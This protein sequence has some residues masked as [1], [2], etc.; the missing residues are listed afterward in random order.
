VRVSPFR[1]ISGRIV[2][3]FFV[4]LVTFAG[5][6]GNTIF[7]MRRVG[8][9]LR[10][11][12]TA[13]LGVSLSVAQ[14]STI[15]NGM[16][17]QLDGQSQ[18][19]K[20]Y[21]RKSQKTRIDRLEQSVSDIERLAD[22]PRRNRRALEQI[23]DN[24]RRFID[25]FKKNDA[26]YEAAQSDPSIMP[27][28]VQREKRLHSQVNSYFNK[29]KNDAIDL[30]IQLENI[31]R[32][33]SLWGLALSSAGVALGIVVALWSVLAL[34]SLR[35]LN[36][37]VR[38][39]AMGNYRERVSVAGG[40]EVADLAQQFN[41]MAAAIE[42]REQELV[43]SAR[44]AAVGKMAAVITHEVRNPL[45]SIALNTDLLEEELAEAGASEALA[46]LRAIQKEVDRLTAITEEYL[47]FARLPRPRLEREQLN[48]IVAGVLELQKEDLHSRGVRVDA[49]LAPSL[50]AVAADEGQLRQALINLLRNAADAMGDGGGAVTIATR[51]AGGGGVAVEVRD[52]GPGIAPEDL[53]RIFE[54][55]F[56]T[57]EGGTG[58]G[59][60]LT[61][62]IVAEHGGRIDVDSVPGRGTT[63]VMT[64]PPLTP[65]S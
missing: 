33:V 50:P 55:F 62:Q 52:T 56:S 3:G 4:L 54:P 20:P 46:L 47:R 6:S 29:L 1:T 26:L 23:Q 58:L 30:T 21:V 2:L 65:P 14:V 22:V 31:E 34:R 36:D 13:Y 15:Q 18:L 43:R 10:F 61:H 35:R 25:E 19:P 32:E 49:E 7:N 27:D 38:S 8:E 16:V 53:P 37:G 17:E 28:L 5:V 12:R 51:P 41:A 59:L 60:A 45:S 48:S 9:H 63:F 57:K 39:V 24:L 44:L 40:T 11:I 42:E 64:L